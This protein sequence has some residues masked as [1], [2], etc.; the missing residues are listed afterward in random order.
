M[1]LTSGPL[2]DMGYSFTHPLS[3]MTINVLKPWTASFHHGEGL[4]LHNHCLISYR[5][6]LLA[7]SH[8]YNQGQP[9]P[10]SKKPRTSWNSPIFLLAP[11]LDPACG[12]PLHSQLFRAPQ[13]LLGVQ[14]PEN[15][16][17]GAPL[18]AWWFLKQLRL[19][20]N[21]DCASPLLELVPGL[22]TAWQLPGGWCGLSKVN[23][24]PL[25]CPSVQAL[26]QSRHRTH[27][28]TTE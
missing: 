7:R 9:N 28:P 20:C 2:W 13:W 19:S 4:H 26:W 18:Q 11:G 16:T 22:P 8:D 6:P 24:L 17:A 14:E 1:Y 23:F 3:A 12:P 5:R 27:N 15:Q 21:S 10:T 25:V